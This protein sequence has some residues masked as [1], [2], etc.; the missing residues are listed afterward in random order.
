MS[1][2]VRLSREAL[3]DHKD[4]PRDMWGRVERAVEDMRAD[5]F[6]GDVKALKGKEWKGYY[7]KRAGP[8]RIIFTVDPK[9]HIV[10][11]IAI[12]R[13]SEKTYR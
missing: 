1:W 7:R 3:K 9:E 2:L 12:I 11:V 4:L 13:R 5:P 6:H 10:G 8:Y